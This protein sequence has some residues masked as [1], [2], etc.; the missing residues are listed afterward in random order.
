[1]VSE[2]GTVV[3][4]VIADMAGIDHMYQYSLNY[5]IKLFTNIIKAAEKSENIEERIDT[6]MK[7][8]TFIIFSNI[9]RGLFNTHKLIFSF[10]LAAKIQLEAKEEKSMTAGE[11]DLFLKGVLVDHPDIKQTRKPHGTED[12]D[13]VFDEKTWRFLLNLE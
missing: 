10:M 11:W 1:M 3:Y 2:R 8:I 4:F 13:T 5:F 12:K 9:C 6:L 7:D